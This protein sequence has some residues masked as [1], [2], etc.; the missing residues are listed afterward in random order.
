VTSITHKLGYMGHVVADFPSP[1]AARDIVCAMVESGITHLEIQIPFSEPVA[2][3]PVLLAANHT[4]LAAGVDFRKSCEF[5]AEV[6]TRF[7]IPVYF[8]TYANVPFRI[9]WERF[10]AEAHK[11][12][13]QGVIV[14]DLPI[15]ESAPF[16]AALSARR[17]HHIRVVAPNAATERIER[18]CRKASGFIYATARAGVTGTKTNFTDELPALIQKIRAFTNVPVAVGFGICSRADAEFLRGVADVAVVGSQ[19]FREWEAGGVGR[20]RSFW[21][22]LTAWP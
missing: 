10:A 2:D 1:Q 11:V 14:P 6:T 16:D 5:A 22:S 17:M 21:K 13:V 12:G 4:A 19:T 9:G 18:I 15:E 3:G 8:M 7:S 20:V